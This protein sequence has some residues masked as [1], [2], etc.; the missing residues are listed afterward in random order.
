MGSTGFGIF[1]HNRIKKA[2]ESA[3]LTGFKFHKILILF[4]K[5][6]ISEYFIMAPVNQCKPFD[7]SKSIDKPNPTAPFINAKLGFELD[8][9]FNEDLMMPIDMFHYVVSDKAAKFLSS[10]EPQI[11]GLDI[12]HK[13]DCYFSISYKS[14]DPGT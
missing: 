6:I 4:K 12:K 11:T 14:R 8:E 5:E 3:D 1:V 13:N 10:I 9:S 2:I 7:F